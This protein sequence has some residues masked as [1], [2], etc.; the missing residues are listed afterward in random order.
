M[1]KRAASEKWKRPQNLAVCR[2][3]FFAKLNGTVQA[4]PIGRKENW[5]FGEFSLII[6]CELWYILAVSFCSNHGFFGLV[7]VVIKMVN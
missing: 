4:A 5:I 7:V 2:I 6:G 3:V 1:E